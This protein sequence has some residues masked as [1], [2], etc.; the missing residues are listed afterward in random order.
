MT[1]LVHNI[2]SGHGIN[3]MMFF[4]TLVAET[5]ELFSTHLP[6]FAALIWSLVSAMYTVYQSWRE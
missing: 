1:L 6:T 4:D 5:D 3:V 2:A